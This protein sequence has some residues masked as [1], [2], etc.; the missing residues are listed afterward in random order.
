MGTGEI[1]TER[2]GQVGGTKES[3]YQ[4][5]MKEDLKGDSIQG[6]RHKHYFNNSVISSTLNVP[7]PRASRSF[8]PLPLTLI[9]LGLKD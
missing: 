8:P 7:Y 1:T 3:Y 4:R 2:R 9:S 5:Q 6:G